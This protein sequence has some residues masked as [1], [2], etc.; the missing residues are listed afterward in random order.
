MSEGTSN[1]LQNIYEA[2][3]SER[4]R[5]MQTKMGMGGTKPGVITRSETSKID[6][7]LQE[8]ISKSASKS[9]HIRSGLRYPNIDIRIQAKLAKG[10]SMNQT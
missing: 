3:E 6:M 4:E 8:Q 10:G 7:R 9:N 2:R 5:C 1:I